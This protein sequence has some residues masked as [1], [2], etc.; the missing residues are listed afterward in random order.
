MPLLLEL[1]PL[2]PEFR[3]IAE[4][5]MGP[6]PAMGPRPMGVWDDECRLGFVPQKFRPELLSSCKK[7]EMKSECEVLA[8]ISMV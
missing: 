5:L 3:P 2:G 7:K 4:A 8:D 1:S 6:D